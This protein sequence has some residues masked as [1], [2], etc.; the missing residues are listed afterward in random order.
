MNASG[1]LFDL[2]HVEETVYLWIRDEKG[3]MVCYCDKYYPAIYIHG[4]DE[5]IRKVVGR[6]QELQALAEPPEW[7]VK[8]HFYSDKECRVLK[9]KVK[10]P[11]VLRRISG[12]LYMFYGIMD[13]Y[14][15]DIDLLSHYMQERRLYPLAEVRFT[16][17]NGI[18]KEI[19]CIHDIESPEYEIPDL[20]IITMRLSGSHRL[21]AGETN[22]LC[23]EI[24]DRKYFVWH[25]DPVRFISKVNAVLELE[26]PDVILS[27]FG[28]QTILPFLFR[29]SNELKIPLNF[30]RDR[31]MK[32]VRRIL[33]EG[34]SYNTYGQWIFRAP[35]Y[36]LFGRWHIDSANSFVYKETELMGIIEL[37]RISRMPVQKLA[38]SSTGT[39]LTNIETFAAIDAGY[40]VPWQKSSLEQPK[41]AYQLLRID[42]GG[43]VFQPYI[44]E[45][46]VYENV[47]QLDFSQ[48]Y[49]SLMVNHNLSPETVNCVCCRENRTGE[50]VPGTHYYVCTRR[51]GVVAIALEK[52][53][54]RRKHYKQRVKETEGQEKELYNARQNSLKW[55]LVTSF[56]YL[57][58][59]NAKFG[60][61]ESHESVTAWGRESLLTAKQ[62]AEEK[63]YLMLHGITDCIFI[64]KPDRS[65][66]TREELQT[67]CREVTEAVNVELAI[68]GIFSWLVFPPSKQDSELPVTNRYFGRFEDGTMKIRGL[69]VRRKD[70]PFWIR[71]VQSRLL[72]IMQEAGSLKEL[73]AMQGR[74]GELYESVIQELHLGKI[75]WQ[76]LAVRK[77]VSK[78]L[79][80]YEVENGTSLS[81]QELKN[82]GSEIQ[83]GEKIQFVVKNQKSKIKSERY[84]SFEK[85]Q[86]EGKE[87]IDFDFNYY[88]KLVYEAFE[89]AWQYFAPKEYFASL[90]EKQNFLSF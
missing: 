20:K 67:L 80:E 34:T 8:R 63:G 13:I 3:E 74:V 89:E 10:K 53:L 33:T 47:A 50:N 7:T 48:M 41:T 71:S 77:T 51:R 73:K 90:K 22:R 29:L 64:Q 59:R 78:H 5:N 62:I 21:P 6:I 15:S 26:D 18:I 88:E 38:R 70:I 83:P 12:K 69:Y 68:E 65:N 19:H 49:P 42:K 79:D 82:I 39:A 31:S 66:F 75:P 4:S 1:T 76:E 44:K 40:L 2:Y 9:V 25:S 72:D 17:E 61:L 84:S 56:G 43:L 87:F 28:D 46:Q 11:S 16:H 81:M 36:P 14:H 86:S 54:K 27:S 55:M 32:T 45:T 37:A 57:G 52:V 35:S 58:Y 24:R 30:D 60:K 85:L 23:F